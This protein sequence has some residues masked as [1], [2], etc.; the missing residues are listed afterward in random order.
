MATVLFGRCRRAPRSVRGRGGRR[1]APSVVRSGLR[2]CGGKCLIGSGTELLHRDRDGGS[3]KR[4]TEEA[5]AVGVLN[6]DNA[7]RAVTSV[8]V[9]SFGTRTRRVKKSAPE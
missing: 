2:E 8:H 6:L 3:S 1:R 9:Q 4:V 5:E 7:G